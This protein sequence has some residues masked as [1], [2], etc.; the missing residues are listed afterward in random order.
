MPINN[1]VLV[2]YKMT[3]VIHVVVLYLLSSEAKAI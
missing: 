2:F 1:T 3:K